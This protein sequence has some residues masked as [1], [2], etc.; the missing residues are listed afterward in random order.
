VIV[1]NFWDWRTLAAGPG[2]P[3]DASG[4]PTW[5]VTAVY[6]FPP[7]ITTW[8]LTFPV[9]LD[10]NGGNADA[11]TGVDEFNWY[12]QNPC[13]LVNPAAARLEL[14]EWTD[15]LPVRSYSGRKRLALTAVGASFVTVQVPDVN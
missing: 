2:A 4:Y 14:Q 12:L 7:S 10:V 1:T 13:E 6:P 11:V 5:P 3:L 8:Q 9:T 15:E